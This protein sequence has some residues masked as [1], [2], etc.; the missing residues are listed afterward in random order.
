MSEVEIRARIKELSELADAAYQRRDFRTE[1]AFDKERTQ[2]EKLL[3]PT[4]TPVTPLTESDLTPHSWDADQIRLIGNS[5]C[6]VCMM[7][8]RY[9]KEGIAMLNEWP[10]GDKKTQSFNDHMMIYSCHKKEA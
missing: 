9:Y 6:S 10:D 7:Q 4:R 2:L 3:V 5:R 8:Y 1:D